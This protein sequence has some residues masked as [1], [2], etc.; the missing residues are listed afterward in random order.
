[1]FRRWVLA[2][3]PLLLVGGRRI[4]TYVAD[5]SPGTPGNGVNGVLKRKAGGPFEVWDPKSGRVVARACISEFGRA[6]VTNHSGNDD[7]P[8]FNIG[9]QDVETLER[10]VR[11]DC[12]WRGGR[13]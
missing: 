9:R 2:G 1:M 6:I 8:L 11:E 13:R 12:P 4:E 5:N 10:A 3:E 7:V